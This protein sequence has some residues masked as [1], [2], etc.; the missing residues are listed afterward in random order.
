MAESADRR[1]A[2]NPPH[3]EAIDR[4]MHLLATLADF[5]SSGVSLSRL[6]DL[7]GISK[8]TAYRALAT[9]RSRGFVSQGAA[10]EYR[11]GISA[12]QLGERFLGDDDVQRLM[13]P[14]LEELARRTE[15]LVHLG[16]WD[17][18]EIVYLDKVE[19][20][21]R[22]IRVWSS[23]GQRVPAACSSLGRALLG[24]SELTGAQLQHYVDNLPADREVSLE[25]L[26]TAVNETR[27][28]GFS[29][30]TEENEPGVACLGLPLMRGDSPI[31]AISI[32][33]IAT[34]MTESRKKRLKTMLRAE[35]P[36][37]LPDGISLYEP[38][39]QQ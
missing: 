7:T 2:S 11:L 22:A 39:G 18:S 34:R 20:A 12:V 30:E 28:T 38:V 15:E 19:P 8:P 32:T 6:A 4:A 25:R 35:L 1:P 3:V 27:E 37:L 17:G 31:A 33:S 24:A 26:Q 9:M 16:V 36:T 23:I 13:H 10:G 5:G 14:V 29:S 21:T